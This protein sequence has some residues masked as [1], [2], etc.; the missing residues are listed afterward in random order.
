MPP[1]PSQ[2]KQLSLDLK[3]LTKFIYELNI[4]RHHTVTYPADHPVIT[5]SIHRSLAHLS[6]LQPENGLLSLGISKNKLAVGRV[7]L[8]EKNPVL[9]E[10]AAHLFS[11]GIAVITLQQNLDERQLRHFLGIIG[12]PPDAAREKGGLLQLIDDCGIKA[13]HIKPIDYNAFGVTEHIDG[14]PANRAAIKNKEAVIWEHFV[15][16]LLTG[17]TAEAHA[18][19]LAGQKLAPQAVA[20]QMN[21]LALK[22]EIPLE[23]HYDQAITEFLRELDRENMAD[24]SNSTTLAR[25]KDLASGLNPE[26]RAQLL[27]ST[28]RAMATN[29]QMAEQVLEKFPGTMLM[30]VLET[31][32]KRQETIPPIIFTLLDRLTRCEVSQSR[33]E[34]SF[35]ITAQDE[36]IARGS[37]QLLSPLYERDESDNFIPAE[38]SRT[39][40]QVEG[41]ARP[42]PEEPVDSHY[43]RSSFNQ[44][45]L[46][47][48]VGDIVFELTR[49]SLSEE[50][51]T[52]FK[53]TLQ[54]LCRQFLDT[55]DFFSAKYLRPPHSPAEKQD[56]RH[57][58]GFRNCAANLMHPSLSNRF[59]IPFK[60]GEKTSLTRSPRCSTPSAP[61][62]LSLC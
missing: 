30:E 31:L 48:K 9:R 4:A 2:E 60:S 58:P 22:E 29:E 28:F 61:P 49:N 54:G 20:E 56:S 40:L 1:Y 10:F 18:P 19:P 15:Q 8:D 33:G 21:D 36:T 59:S 46:E 62:P 13:I 27:N 47:R 41:P 14:A 45:S 34:A 24:M 12:Q 3:L 7:F 51:S 57:P 44:Q 55:G 53:K 17:H 32:N 26:L 25:L 5:Q 35:N 52:T 50:K 37:E 39:L 43:W 16:S 11:H 38:Y 42:N 6:Q 23:G